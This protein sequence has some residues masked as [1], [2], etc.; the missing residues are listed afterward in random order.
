M[1]Q[2][3]TY[4]AVGVVKHT[5][6]Y[7]LRRLPSHRQQHENSVEYH[8]LDPLH[9]GLV[10]AATRNIHLNFVEKVKPLACS[11]DRV[12]VQDVDMC[13]CGSIFKYMFKVIFY[14][15]RVR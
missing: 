13:V 8:A 1:S 14:L 9:Y 5:R 3:A 10:C 6:Y 4:C 12:A 7:D 11:M 2:H 15:Y